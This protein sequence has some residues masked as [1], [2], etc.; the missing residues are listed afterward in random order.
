[1]GASQR[2]GTRRPIRV[3]TTAEGSDAL[4]GVVPNEPGRGKSGGL[5]GRNRRAAK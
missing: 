2:E 5:E 1:M 3:E 4:V